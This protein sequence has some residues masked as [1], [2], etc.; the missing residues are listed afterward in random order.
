MGQFREL[1]VSMQPK[2]CASLQSVC[3]SIIYPGHVEEKRPG[4][5]CMRMRNNYQK[6][7]VIRLCLETVGKINTYTSDIFPY[8]WKV[9]PFA[10]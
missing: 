8:H 7:L 3:E 4:I 10:G 2:T 1:I 6:N 5:D 9:Q